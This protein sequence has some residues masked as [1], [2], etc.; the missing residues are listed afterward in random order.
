[1]LTLE[2]A[3]ARLLALV[4]PSKTN[5][6]ETH[7]ASGLYLA[8]D[9]A[10]ARTQPAADLS[11]MDG[12]A[13]CG[14]GPW[15]RIGE[16]RAG[17]PFDGELAHGEC[18]RIST[19]AHMPNG[20]DRVLIQE[21]A[22]IEGTFV[23]LASGETYPEPGMHVRKAG[24]DFSTGETVLKMGTCIGP[25]QIAL[26]AAA[27]Q[28]YLPVSSPPK[29]AILESGDE[30]VRLPAEIDEHQIPASNGVM[31]A[32][33]VA[34]IAGNP[35]ILGPV[36][37]DMDALA[38]ALSNA[39]NCD[40]LITSAGASVGEHDLIQRA[41]EEWGAEIDFW[42]VAIKPGKPLMIATRM[43]NGRRQIILGLPGNPVSSFVTCFLFAR[44]LIRAMMG[45]A[46]PLPIAEAVTSAV[47]IPS[48]GSRHEFLRGS[49]QNGEASM[50]DNQDSSALRAL[51]NANCLIDRPPN[52]PAVATGDAVKIFN[53]DNGA[54]LRD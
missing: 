2:E 12:Y 48:G 43:T 45:S 11:A 27:G 21:N 47:D 30:L 10:A 14:T 5:K 50:T 24:F 33:M 15:T 7:K 17:T 3:Q 29:I 40:V 18:T 35:E 44:P 16:S 28:A 34:P 54:I 1:M 52:C 42:K 13:T 39:D 31:L 20:S 25:A 49:L 46:A 22:S 38:V 26:A 32:A 23:R 36:P 19:G 9:V 4:P 41:L 8:E 51:G 53:L 6:I 37:D